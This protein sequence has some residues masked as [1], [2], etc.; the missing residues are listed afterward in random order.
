MTDR[1]SVTHSLTH[2]PSLERSGTDPELTAQLVAMAMATTCAPSV[3]RP[4]P[5]T[6]T[7]A[8]ISASTQVGSLPVARSQ[9]RLLD[10]SGEKRFRCGNCGKRFMEKVTRRGLAC[11]DM[12][13][14]MT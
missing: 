10:S 11:L 9:A 5:A 7:S 1:L 8:A 3:T 2:A 13:T 6:R 12:L 4:S 14:C